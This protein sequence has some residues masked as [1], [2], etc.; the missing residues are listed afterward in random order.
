MLDQRLDRRKAGAAGDQD[1]GLGRFLAQEET[2]VGALQTQ[3]VLFLHGTEYVS[4][5][6]AAGNQPHMQLQK[7][8]V[9]RRVGDGKGAPLAVLEHE[10][11]VLA[12]KELQA[13][14]G[15][16]LQAEDDDI[17]GDALD[18]LDAGRHDLDR[19]VPRRAHFAAFQHQVGERLGATE[20]RQAAGAVGDGQGLLLRRAVI[21]QAIEHLALAGAAGA[22]AAAVGQ[23]QA[24]IE[25]RLQQGIAAVGGKTVA[26]GLQ[27]DAKWSDCGHAIIIRCEDC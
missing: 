14:V 19:N 11:D 3:D 2:A 17:I 7:A 22:V 12:G 5:E 23:R 13:L 15:R 21:H 18:T 27:G 10:L 25:R 16:Q 9:M 24:G 4:G 26:A 1:H 8:V 20:Q 6:F